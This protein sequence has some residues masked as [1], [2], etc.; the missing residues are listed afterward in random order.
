MACFTGCSS[1]VPATMVC[2]SFKLPVF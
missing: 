1:P 2:G